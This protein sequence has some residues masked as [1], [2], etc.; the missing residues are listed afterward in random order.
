MA[1]H[2]AQ[3]AAPIGGQADRRDVDFGRK[4]AHQHF[5]RRVEFERRSDQ[6][7]AWQFPADHVA[8][9]V[10]EPLEISGGLRGLLREHLPESAA[11]LESKRS[12]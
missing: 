2:N 7:Y 9:E 5:G 3:A 1:K 12:I 6:Q 8:G 10:T 11:V 4:E